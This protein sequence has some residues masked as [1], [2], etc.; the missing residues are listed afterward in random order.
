MSGAWYGNQVDFE[1]CNFGALAVIFPLLERMNVASIIDQHLPADTRAEFP[2]GT[3][4]SLLIAARLHRPTALMN[5][6]R[7]AAESGADF[8]WQVPVEKLN[9]ERLGRSM[10]AFFQQRHSI[11]AQ[12]ALHISQEFGVPLSEL[13]FDPT[14]VL[15]QGAYE[16][17]EAR[18]GVVGGVH[19]P[20][21]RQPAA[22]A[23]HQRLGGARHTLTDDE[24]KQSI[25]CRVIFVFSTA[26]KKVVRKQR[27][28]Q[29]DKIREG[30]E[31]VQRSVAEG[32]RSTDPQA[33]ARRVQKL[34]GARQAARYF[35]YTM[36]PLSPREQ[37]GLPKPSR[38]CKPT[39]HRFSFTFDEAALRQD[40][41][42]DGYSALVTT[43]TY[44]N[45]RKIG[46]NDWASERLP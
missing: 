26:D 12:L 5:V 8:L 39:T 45:P 14:H 22:G 44:T 6:A 46:L 38:G 2:H 33:G 40:E 36:T 24:S 34:Y 15:F 29:I 31:A 43:A 42:D 19:H 21:R 17:A 13:H 28:K 30:L 4:L 16:E 32:R 9:D 23:H 7:W 27:Q 20:Q 10:D 25:A 1:A 37:A 35:S 18:E 11:L 41:A 3:I